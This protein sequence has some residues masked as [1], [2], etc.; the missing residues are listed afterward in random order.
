MEETGANS[1]V[2]L[3]CCKCWKNF[4]TVPLQ[5]LSFFLDAEVYPV[6][7]VVGMAN[8]TQPEDG[9]STLKP[10]RNINGVFT[11]LH[12]SKKLVKL[13][14]QIYRQSS[15]CRKKRGDAKFHPE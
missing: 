14:V 10:Q 12:S 5:E 11:T 1:Q 6:L 7:Q 15:L 4:A 13:I 8:V 3:R 2:G 9:V